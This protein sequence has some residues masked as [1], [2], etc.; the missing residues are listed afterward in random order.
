M[1]TGRRESDAGRDRGAS[2]VEF[3]LILPVLAMLLLGIVTGGLAL[4]TKN[5]MT[6]AVREATRFG[7]TLPEGTSWN[8]W[9]VAVRD[10][11]VELAGDDLS[12]AQ[13]CAQVLRWDSSTSTASVLGSWPAS[14][15]CSLGGEPA[16]PANTPHDTCVVKVWA[17]RTA[18]LD[19]LVFRRDLTLRAPAVG[20]YERAAC[21]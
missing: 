19:T 21:P 8:D 5:S 2:M 15:G 1:G 6:N 12:D 9:A 14:G 10:R 3:A 17:E 7:A 11:A 4:G 13:V 16:V 18:T 20:Q